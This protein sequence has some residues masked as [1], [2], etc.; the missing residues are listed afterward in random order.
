MKRPQLPIKIKVTKNLFALLTNRLL[1]RLGFGVV[2]VFIP[3]FFYQLF[4][5]SFNALLWMYIGTY[6]LRFFLI[7]LG[8]MLLSR[9]GMRTMMMLAVPFAV[10]GM[11]MLAFASGNE[12]LVA[13]LV[14]AVT[15]ALYSVFYWVPYHTDFTRSIMDYKHPGAS[16]A[17]YKNA[18]AVMNAV[19]PLVG[20][21]MIATYG[22]EYVFV[23]SGIALLS[24]IVPIYVMGHA[25]ERYAWGYG[26]TF[27]RLFARKNR[28]LL[29]AYIADGGQTIISL[30]VWPVFI[31]ELLDGNYVSVGFMA[32]LTTL[33]IFLLNVVVGKF[34]DRVGDEKALTYSSILAATG[35]IAKF[36]V[37]SAFQIF[38][39][40]TYHKLGSA[41]NRMSFDTATYEHSADNGSYVDEFTTLK[42]LAL[43]IGRVLVL[44][45]VMVLLYYLENI[46]FTFL[47]AAL[48]TVAMVALNRQLSVR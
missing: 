32:S 36:F 5:L 7:P 21:V 46:R 26:E 29:Y 20:G 30:V 27:M 6:T 8:S 44:L 13:G 41:A 2:G 4:D 24:T 1:Y 18:L 28:A 47:I 14:Y 12:P 34:V 10:A 23:F 9:W 38:V 19:T 43:N 39:V 17:W 40:D 25:S 3:I 16:I 45:L 11:S 31:F 42:E 22:F 48:A 37:D 33:A 35:W 15:M